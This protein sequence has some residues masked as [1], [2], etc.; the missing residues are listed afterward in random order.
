[1]IPQFKINGVGGGGFKPVNISTQ[2]KN[3]HPKDSE[4]SLFSKTRK[5]KEQQ[6]GWLKAFMFSGAAIIILYVQSMTRDMEKVSEEDIG[7][8]YLLYTC[9]VLLLAGMSIVQPAAYI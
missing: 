4:K 3:S 2:I 5:S 9:S 1:M 7:L 6:G 8:I